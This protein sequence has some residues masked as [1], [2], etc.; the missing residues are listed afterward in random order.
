MQDIDAV[1]AWLEAQGM[2]T[3]RP[4][5]GRDG[6]WLWRDEQGG[7]WRIMSHVD[8]HSFD[9]VTGPAMAAEAGAMAAR[10][11][12]ALAGCPHEF[13]HVRAGVHDTGAHL[14][15][16]EALVGTG[17]KP[18]LD[19]EAAAILEHARSLPSW[20]ELPRRVTHGDLKLSNVLF[21]GATPPRAVALIDLDTLGRQTLAYEIG[22]ALRSWCNRGGE[23]DTQARFDPDVFAAAVTGYLGTMGSS[24]HAEERASL[25]PGLETVACELAARFSVDAYEDRYFGWDATRFAT[26]VEHN[27]VRALGQLDLARQVRARRGE[28]ERIVGDA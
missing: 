19:A 25:V 5:S 8:G 11:H 14:A 10:F 18:E 26:R 27:R 23:D 2:A 17:G 12:V 6:A 24:I 1:T 7:R 28:L 21:D 9:R 16:L 15:R 20:P 4:L 3:Q 22:D 13:V